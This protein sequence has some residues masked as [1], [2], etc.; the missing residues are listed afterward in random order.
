MSTSKERVILRFRLPSDK[1]FIR[2]RSLAEV[3]ELICQESTAHGIGHTW[4]NRKNPLGVFWFL[5]TTSLFILLLVVASRLMRDFIQRDIQSQT[6]VKMIKGG[7]LQLP[8]VVLCNRHLFS[9][10]KLQA[11]NITPEVTNY[12]IAITGSAFL[13]RQD[14]LFTAAGRQFLTDS[15]SQLLS[16]MSTHNLTHSQLIDAISYRCEELVLRC[17]VG[18][19]KMDTEEC[20]MGFVVTPTMAGKCYT[21]FAAA[22]HTQAMEGEYLGVSLYINVTQDDHPEINPEILDVSQMVKTGLQMTLV[23]NHTHP[24]FVAVGQGVPLL[25]GVYTAVDVSLT[26]VRDVGIKTVFD[27]SETECIPLEKVNYRL[28]TENFLNTEPN[29]DVGASRLCFKHI[30]NCSTYGLDNS[31]DSW[32]PC[33]LNINFQCFSI[34]LNAM[35]VT[36]PHNAYS[37]SIQEDSQL[38]FTLADQCWN[39]A[40]NG[41]RRPCSR[42]DY[43]Y[44]STHLPIQT[45]LYQ[46]LRNQFSLQNGS[47]VAVAVAFFPNLRYTEIKRWRKDIEAFMSEL[48]GYTGVFLGCSFITFIETFVFFGLILAV[49]VRK[50]NIKFC[51]SVRLSPSKSSSHEMK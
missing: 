50:I 14:F 40:K 19:I 11:L 34:M 6:T 21:Y 18:T 2:K 27:W 39:E 32:N 38:N 37:T 45:Y 15:H 33:S 30:C 51:N 46:D 43:M 16:I 10:W 1:D 9:R 28:D 29:C 26:V 35:N 36:P 31:V 23:S 13:L 49:F 44:T 24:A 3:G 47:D 17:G 48:G 12:L 4:N 7:E 22:N 41:C 5:A 8:S 20:C 25:P 42:Y